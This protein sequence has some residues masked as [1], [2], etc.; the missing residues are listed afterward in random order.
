MIC[1][2]TVV[3]HREIIGVGHETI[4]VIARLIVLG[5][6]LVDMA[7]VVVLRFADAVVFLVTK[8]EVFAGFWHWPVWVL[9]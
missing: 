5:M 6:R 9:T 4:A 7:L 3:A 1:R 8:I 2:E